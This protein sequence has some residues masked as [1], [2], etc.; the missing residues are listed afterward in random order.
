M[1][2]DIGRRVVLTGL[3]AGFSIPLLGKLDAEAYQTPDPRLIRP[4][5]SV[6]EKDFLALCQR[7]GLCMKVCPTN[8]INPTLL[9][10][11][12]IGFWTP[13]L[14]MIKGYCE[15]TCTLCGQVCPTGAIER[16]TVKEKIQEPVKIGSAYLD[17]GRCLPWS[18]NGA[19]IVCEEHCPTSPKAIYFKIEVI[20]GRNGKKEEV[21]LPYVDLKECTGCGICEYKCPVIGRPA[22]LV[23]SAGES[24]SLENR[25][26]L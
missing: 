24:R 11:G 20:K 2:P 26:L 6:N 5:G 12:V 13:H 19:C 4:P 15:H 21:K 7:C 8:V 3:L 22:I 14:V 10:A 25:I 9:E 16:L 23:I 18:G 17:R 1:S